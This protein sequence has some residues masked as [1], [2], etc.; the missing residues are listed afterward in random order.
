MNQ[1]IE[2]KWKSE[3]HEKFNKADAFLVFKF[4][5]HETYANAVGSVESFIENL[6]EQERKRM[7]DEVGKTIESY[8]VKEEP[9]C[10]QNVLLNLIKGRVLAIINK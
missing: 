10:E 3:F 9:L 8:K 1:P 5:P 4:L 7:S 6:L 2:E